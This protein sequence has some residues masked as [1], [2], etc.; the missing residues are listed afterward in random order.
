MKMAQVQQRAKTM[1]IPFFRMSKKALIRNIQAKEGNTA[2]YLT[3]RT[4]CDQF[5]CCWRNDCMGK[6]GNS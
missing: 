5:E 4:S 6:S 2:C 1:G 3:G